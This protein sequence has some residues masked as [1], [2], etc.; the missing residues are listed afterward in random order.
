MRRFADSCFGLFLQL[1][2]CLV[3][4]V[5]SGRWSQSRQRAIVPTRIAS[6]GRRSEREGELRPPQRAGRC[7]APGPAR[8]PGRSE[9]FF[10]GASPAILALDLDDP[11]I[12]A[13]EPG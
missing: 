13:A 1:L 3:C 7:P 11:S 6:T 4:R 8:A 5:R 9:P 2:G 10:A 12:A